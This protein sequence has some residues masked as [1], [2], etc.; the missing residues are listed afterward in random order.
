M[1]IKSALI[2]LLTLPVLFCG[3]ANAQKQSVSNRKTDFSGVV[4]ETPSKSPVAGAVVSLPT[5]GIWTLTD[6]DGRFTVKS[7]PEGETRIVIS[8]VSMVTVDKQISIGKTQQTP[9]QFLMEVE[10]FGLDEVVVTA[11]SNKVGASTSS[12]ISRSAMDHLQ[13]TSLGDILELLP[14]Q[15][16]SNPTLN[17]PA[18][19][20]LRQ[21]Q[22]DALNSMG[23]SIVFNGA[24]ISNNA[25]MQ[26][27]NTAQDGT[28]NT[29]FTSTA[30]SGTDLRQ[31]SVDNIESVD[32]IRGIPSV[33]YG[34]LT[35]G[36]IIINPKAGEYP[37]QVK[38]KINPTLTQ[39]SAGKGF[40]LGSK[41]GKLTL[42]LDYA[43]SLSDERRPYQ[44]FK[45]LTAN[46]LYSNKLSNEIST[47]T[48]FGFYSDLDAQKLDPS[49]ER[50]QRKRT[51]RNT[52]YKFN[53]NILWSANRNFLKFIRLNLSADYA[54]QEGY[55][56]EI[57]G[58]FG[59]MVTSAMKDGTVA[60]NRTEVIYDAKGNPITN[61]NLIDPGASTN[62][63]PYEYL[64]K[65][66]TYGK[67]LT[68]F[69]K[70][71]ANFSGKVGKVNNRILVG[72][73]WNTD[74]NFGRGRVFDPLMPPESG[75]R[76]RPFKDIP[77]LHQFSAFAEEN[78]E[79]SV[80]KR[81]LKVQLGLRYDMIQPLKD[82]GR[83]VLSPR[84]NASF[85]IIPNRLTVRGG[86]GITAKAPPLMYLY[87]DNAYYDFIN[88]DNLGQSGLTD[89]QRLSI[90]TTKVYDT[91]NSKLKIAQ[92]TK[93]EIGLE[94]QLPGQRAFT[95]T[96]YD[97]SVKN[98]YSF[99]T[100]F[101]SFKTFNLIKYEATEERV[102]N[103]PL[104]AEKERN[105]IV[106]CYNM[107]LNNKASHNK[108]LEFDFDFG[109]IKPLNTS[110]VLT[111]AWMQSRLTSTNNSFYQKNPVN[112]VYKDIGVY[113]TGDGSRYDR[114][115]SN[116]RIIHNIP[117]VSFL[118]SLSIQT[119]WKDQHRYLGTENKTP[120]GY[121]SAATLEYTPLNPGDPISDDLQKQILSNR[122]ITESYKF[123]WLFNL[124][125]TKE[126]PRFGGFAFFVNNLFMYRPM[127][128]SSRNP[129]TYTYRNP[130]QF[131]GVELWVKL[132]LSK[133]KK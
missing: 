38:M 82:I 9:A 98:G 102:G 116:L 79:T 15:L 75:V 53:T 70:L 43:S 19:A 127:E 73:N 89:D 84:I 114:I 64:T 112:G 52:G 110:F 90:I 11:K 74:A 124:R 63:L 120:I 122:E 109:Q 126:I 100:D 44:G 36:V 123:L 113:G 58:N 94:L 25:N 129:G 40:D 5:Y 32:V 117:R 45:R 26:V 101:A 92:N 128:E 104:L 85:E 106:L 115:S 28:L 71:L 2:A 37:L 131:F 57:K 130:E 78:I 39:V 31:I 16:A 125:L 49:D 59:Y 55:S 8:M 34:D 88:Y 51:S 68:L 107:P 118:V 103:Y 81:S 67:P 119:I 17:S 46:T 41:A 13:A 76:M 86:Y 108:G 93:K 91:S 1:K 62:I 24:P 133:S 132:G 60:S 33:E 95:L 29:A 96:Y 61:S 77:A 22:S 35:S 12:S 50:Y 20:S 10:S 21:V 54:V 80:L 6:D 42:D 18:T 27:G 7:V 47:T 65:S 69:G 48:G 14:G 23:T 3:T 56:Q 105:K 4:L 99:G 121:I 87:P 97:E 83:N 66:T 72:A 30:G 111:G